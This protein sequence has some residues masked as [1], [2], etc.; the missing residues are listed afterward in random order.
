MVLKILVVTNICLH[1]LSSCVS[2]GLCGPGGANS[3]GCLR[4]I[5]SENDGW[6]LLTMVIISGWSHDQKPVRA[7]WNWAG[8][9]VR[10]WLLDCLATPENRNQTELAELRDGWGERSWGLGKYLMSPHHA[11]APHSSFQLTSEPTPSFFVSNKYIW[12]NK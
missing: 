4:K 8:G 5:R 1:F 2:S 3:R 10:A 7:S 11:S 6:T 9:E 12:T